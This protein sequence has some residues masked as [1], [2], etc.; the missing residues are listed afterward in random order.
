MQGVWSADILLSVM[1]AE[2]TKMRAVYFKKALFSLPFVLVGHI[3]KR[4]LTALGWRWRKRAVVLNPTGH[5]IIYKYFLEDVGAGC[6][7]FY[8]LYKICLNFRIFMILRF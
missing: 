1:F 6:L 7:S 8:N 3:E 2:E 5:L 4:S